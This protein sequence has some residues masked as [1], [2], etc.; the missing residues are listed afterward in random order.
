[1]DKIIDSLRNDGFQIDENGFLNTKGTKISKGWK[2]LTKGSY[3]IIIK[4]GN[5][6]MKIQQFSNTNNNLKNFKKEIDTQ[7]MVYNCTKTRRSLTPKIFAYGKNWILMKKVPGYTISYW[8][9]TDRKGVFQHA[10]RAYINALKTI[11]RKCGIGHFDAHGGNAVYDRWTGAIKILDWGF[12]EP[13]SENDLTREGM[14]KK[15][16]EIYNRKMGSK[17]KATSNHKKN[18]IGQFG[19]EVIPYNKRFDNL[20]P[21][22]NIAD[23]LTILLN[24]SNNISF[25]R[26]RSINK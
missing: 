7:M 15:Y 10:I 24:N 12:A 23:F 3:G 6:I 20:K 8:Y 25:K 19:I 16:K 26:K 1:M 11:H 5:M 4:K 14:L 9:R 18:L 21:K 22:N 2:Y 17:W 13:V